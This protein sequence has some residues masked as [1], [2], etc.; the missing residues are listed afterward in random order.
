MTDQIDFDPSADLTSD[1][2]APHLLA[3]TLQHVPFDGWSDSAIAAGARDL[4][5]DA[6]RAKLVFES[7]LQALLYH[8]DAANIELAH[9]LAAADMDA[10][11]IRQRISFA[12]LTRFELHQHHKEAVRRGLTLLSLP[13]NA[14]YGSKSLWQMADIMWRAAGDTATD[15]NYY[16]KR[17]ILSAVYSSTLLIWLGDDS[18]DLAETKAF[19]NR[20]IDNVMQFE[21]AKASLKKLDGYL[22]SP[23][24]FLSRLRY[25]GGQ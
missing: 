7:G 25:G 18:D 19:L 11:K 14:A 4:G 20:R 15:F 2:I 12:I 22:P 21:K 9:A 16:S 13:Q 5:L 8:L 24:R 6:G 17:T 10:M 23:S 3:A 1:E